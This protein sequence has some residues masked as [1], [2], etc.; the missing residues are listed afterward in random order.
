MKR[1]NNK[2]IGEMGERIAIGELAKFNINVLLPMSDNLP[3]DFVIFHKNE[4]FKCQVKTT[5]KNK[6]DIMRFNITSNNWNKHTT[7]KYTSEEVDVI[8][9]CDLETIYLF[10]IKEVENKNNIYLRKMSP[11]NNQRKGVK[12][13]KDYVISEE[14]IEQVLYGDVG[15]VG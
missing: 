8:I 7:H 15:R 11:K 6:N 1:K 14:R 9:C 3:F 5:D 13:A 4:F 12:F 10:S 2:E